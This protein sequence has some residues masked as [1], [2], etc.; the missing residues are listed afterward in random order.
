MSTISETIQRTQ[1][2]IAAPG[3]IDEVCAYIT[4]GGTLAAWCRGDEAGARGEYVFAMVAAWVE[5]DKDRRGRYRDAIAVREQHHKDRII[6]QLIGM[7]TADLTKAFAQDGTL[8]PID[9]IP[10]NVRHWIAGIE[11]E[12]V[13]AGKGEERRQIGYTKK[14]K[15]WDKVRSTELLMKN[16]KMLVDRHEVTAFNLADLLAEEPE[17]RT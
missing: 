16:L 8:L 12:E 11:I 2:A 4:G 13:F 6:E 14:I 5:L 10:A 1:D 17:R 9:Q 3:A 15:F 7:V